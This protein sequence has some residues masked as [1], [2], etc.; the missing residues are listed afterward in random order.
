MTSLS[1]L[2]PRW[3]DLE[4][5]FS[6]LLGVI[7]VIA[8]WQ[9]FDWRFGARLFPQVVGGVTLL[10][11]VSRVIGRVVMVV[12]GSEPPP[13][14]EIVDLPVDDS[15]PPAEFLRRSGVV[16]AWVFGFV[17]GA[18]LVGLPIAIPVYLVSYLRLQAGLAWWK[19]ALFA[20]GATFLVVVAFGQWMGIRLPSGLLLG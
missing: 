8:L 16:F 15:V 1:N 14:D 19:A 6:I 2:K 17:L 5:G 10:L 3:L 20:A 18:M 12:R 9:S 13:P 11:I 4:L 7:V